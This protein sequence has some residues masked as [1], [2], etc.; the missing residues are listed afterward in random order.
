[1][2]NKAKQNNI[3]EGYTIVTVSYT[4]QHNQMLGTITGMLMAL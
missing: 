2:C 3:L 1:M 4:S